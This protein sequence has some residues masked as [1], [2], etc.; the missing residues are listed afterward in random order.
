MAV[1]EKNLRAGKAILNCIAVLLFFASHHVAAAENAKQVRTIDLKSDICDITQMQINSPALGIEFISE[2]KAV[3]FTVCVGKGQPKL[4]H[5]NQFDESSQYLRAAVFNVMTGQVEHR[6]SW[7]THGDQS[8]VGVTKKGNLLVGRDNVLDTF[9]LNGKQLAHLQIERVKLQDPLL[10]APSYAAG[11]VSVTELAMTV[12]EVLLTAT[13]VLDSD[14]LRPL[15]KWNARNAVQDRVITG[16]PVMAA[17]W[18]EFQGEKHVVFRKPGDTEWKTAWTGSTYAIRGPDFIGPSRF[19]M[20]TD[21]A[22]MIFN[23]KGKME[24]QTS[25]HDPS[26][27]SIAKDGK[28]L[29]VASSESSSSPA[30]L[31]STRIDVFTDTFQR[32]ATFT[33][34]AN[35]DHYFVLAL[36][37]T[38]RT[39]AILGN[40]KVR[41]YTITE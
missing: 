29:V 32:T 34:F 7:P 11:S 39:L 31:P 23:G 10:I 1:E 2:E 8:F 17:G 41:V 30:F 36:S 26:Q 33:N 16:S 27:F 18:Q 6:L 38:A 4:S 28:H 21:R 12:S 25:L 3:A 37:P 9:D 19:V 22:V 14:T 20:A 13:V 40:M 15:Y 5:R 35:Q 24:G